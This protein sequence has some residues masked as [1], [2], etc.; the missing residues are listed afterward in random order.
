MEV[1][2]SHVA[3]LI[4]SVVKANQLRKAPGSDACT[5]Q[6]CAWLPAKRN[7]CAAEVKHINFRK[8]L[9][10][11]CKK[12]Q[13]EAA[14]APPTS[15]QLAVFHASLQQVSARPVVHRVMDAYAQ[16]F[17]PPSATDK[18]PKALSSLHDPDSL[19]LTYPHFLQKCATVS[20]S[21]KITTQQCQAVEEGTKGQ[22]NCKIWLA[23]RAGR[24]TASNFKSAARTNPAMPS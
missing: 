6:K 24:I 23:Q 16:E 11:T 12:P 18:Y 14:I 21:I 15:D 19:D 4:S 7:V 10:S 20:D 17:I 5:S 1:A 3:A 9:T 22:A 8:P 13:T 2:C